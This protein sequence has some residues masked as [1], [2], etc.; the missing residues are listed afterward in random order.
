MS[1]SRYLSR[2][3]LDHALGVAAYPMPAGVWLAL[4]NAVGGLLSGS[5]DDEVS[6]GAYVRQAVT[7][8]AA[9]DADGAVNNGAVEFPVAT[10]DWGDMV[11]WALVDAA[12]GGNVLHWGEFPQYGEPAEYKSVFVGD[13]FRIRDGDLVLTEE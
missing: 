11:G 6:G 9:T 10:E 8:H 5:L 12:V 4:F 7:F 1:K 2:K 3:V 13:S